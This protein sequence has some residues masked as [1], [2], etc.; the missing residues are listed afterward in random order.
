MKTSLQEKCFYVLLGFVLAQLIGYTTDLLTTSESLG[1]LAR[2]H[3]ERL[4]VVSDQVKKRHDA[5]ASFIEA[6]GPFEILEQLNGHMTVQGNLLS[7]LWAG[8]EQLLNELPPVARHSAATSEQIIKQV[9]DNLPTGYSKHQGGTEKDVDEEELNA[10]DEEAQGTSAYGEVLP[11]STSRI[12]H[13]LLRIQK[14]DV[15]ADMGSGTGKVPI[16]ACLEALADACY[17]IELSESRHAV[18]VRALEKLRT[19]PEGSRAAERT[20]FILGSVTDVETIPPGLTVV[21]ANM[22]TWP[23]E[24][25]NQLVYTLAIP[26]AKE[27]REIRLATVGTVPLFYSHNAY[28]SCVTERRDSRIHTSWSNITQIYVYVIQPCRKLLAEE[29]RIQNPPTSYTFER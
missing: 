6:Y 28:S 5:L 21:F 23:W 13:H 11:V 27:N 2:G 15:F 17:G 22:L 16:Q 18:A 14:G 4:R 10:M 7:E 25:I 9:Y 29:H 8:V 20:H 1:C 3:A 19:V 26:A 24:L 12:L